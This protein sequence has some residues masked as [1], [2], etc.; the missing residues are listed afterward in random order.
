MNKHHIIHQVVTEFY[1][2]A[3]QDILIGHHFRKIQEIEVTDKKQL[4]A[5]PI[6]AFKSHLPRIEH[7]WRVQLLAEPLHTQP[8]ELIKIHK[9]L[10]IRRGELDRWVQLFLQILQNNRKKYCSEREKDDDINEE[11]LINFFDQWEK[12]IHHFAKIFKKTKGMFS[13]PS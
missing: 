8:F 2:Q 3:T 7:F 6:E 5:P 13:T 12:K 9:N 11:K 4:L 10:L 1:T